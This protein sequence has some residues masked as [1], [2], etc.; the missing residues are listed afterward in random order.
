MPALPAAVTPAV[1]GT[2]SDLLRALALR[3]SSN[4]PGAVNRFGYLGL[5]QMGE[6]AL[7]DA[8]FYRADGTTGNDWIGSWTATAQGYGVRSRA[9]FLASRPA[10]TAALTAFWRAQ[11]RV[12]DRLG[13][14]DYVGRAVDGVTLTP[15]GLLAG[16][17]LVG[18]GGLRRHLLASGS[19][20]PMDGNGVR[21]S[22]YITRFNNYRIPFA[23]ERRPADKAL[24][25]ADLLATRPLAGNAVAGLTPASSASVSASR[26]MLAT[27][28]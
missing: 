15:S 13:L 3:E 10:Q 18:V 27:P 21:V 9:G 7:I 17:H 19:A 8:G 20:E 2:W 5:Y 22:A 11:W 24:H 16:A 25:M 23:T 28:T 14:D 26:S 6:A 12:I 4:R 1:R